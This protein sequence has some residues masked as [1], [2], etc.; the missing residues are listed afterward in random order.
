MLK[1]KG[2]E[3]HILQV[4]STEPFSDALGLGLHTQQ[5]VGP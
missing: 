3:A 2:N 1:A 5:A 4:D